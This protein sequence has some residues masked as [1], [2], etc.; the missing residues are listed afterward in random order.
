MSTC[1]LLM[2]PL[3]E[4]LGTG[5]TSFTYIMAVMA[6]M[7]FFGV[8]G[9]V[10]DSYTLDLLGDQERGKYGRYR[11]WL[12]VSWGVGN[13]LMGLVADHLGFDYNF[14]ISGSLNMLAISAPQRQLRMLSR[15]CRC[16]ASKTHEHHLSALFSNHGAGASFTDPS[17][18]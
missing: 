17:R 2:L 11:L 5:W 10:L 8:G 14:I 7:S 18:A 9:G 6:T 12:A 15:Y 13:A 4:W 3:P 16:L 1:L